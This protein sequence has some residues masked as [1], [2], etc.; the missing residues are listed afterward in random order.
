[1][2]QPTEIVVYRNPAEYALWHSNFLFVAMVGAVV[3]ICLG[4]AVGHLC[5]RLPRN[6]ARHADKLTILVVI[7]AFAIVFKVMM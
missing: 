5:N 2:N 4:V 3:A 1:M 7:V 6:Y